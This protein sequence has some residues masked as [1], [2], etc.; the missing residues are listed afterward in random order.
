MIFLL[1]NL[2][3]GT[4]FSRMSLLTIGVAIVHGRV[5]PAEPFE[6]PETGRGLLT[7]FPATTAVRDPLAPHPI[8]S[9]GRILS[10]PTEPLSED[11]WP[12]IQR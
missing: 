2:V 1:A 11:E 5:T 8:L 9:K 7:I 3:P 10:D 6:L 4:I 12:E